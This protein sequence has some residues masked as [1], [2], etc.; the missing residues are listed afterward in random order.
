MKLT[1]WGQGTHICVNKLTSINSDNGLS[2]DWHQAIIWTN[3]GILL[4]EPLGI[5][6]SEILIEILT[7]SFKKMRLKV[8]SANGG[9]VV[10]ASMA[11]MMS[12]PQCVNSLRPSDTYIC[13]GHHC[14]NQWWIVVSW[15][16]G[17][18]LN[19]F[20]QENEFEN[21]VC[22]TA[23]ILCQPQ[24]VN[25]YKELPSEVWWCSGYLFDVKKIKETSLCYIDQTQTEERF[26]SMIYVEVMIILSY[27]IF[28]T[29][30]QKSAWVDN[31]L[32]LK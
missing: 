19:F 6:Y 30:W 18:K 23:S 24:W 14:L 7:F 27:I 9:H 17:N 11:A 32:V 8:S 21:V 15:T 29:R 10:L 12:W 22:E 2:P 4:I 20:S 26:A 13:L 3:A 28:V 16:L 25:V 31:G 5:K 1:H